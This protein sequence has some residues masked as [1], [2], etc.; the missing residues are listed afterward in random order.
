MKLR[1]VYIKSHAGGAGKWIYAGY[2]RAWESMGYE[3]VHYD[4]LSQID[5]EPNSYYLMAIDGTVS[6][7]EALQKV[8]DSYKTFLYVQPNEFPAPWGSH[9]NFQCHCPDEFIDKLNELKN[10]I[11][12]VFGN[13]TKYHT[14]W[15]KFINYIPL[16]FDNISYQPQKDDNYAY[17]ICFVGGW[18]DNG[19]NEKRAIMLAHFDELKKLNINMGICIN[20]G[21]SVQDEANLLYNSKISLNIHDQY[22]RVYGDDS[23]ERTFKS[24]GL[25][26]FLICDKVREVKRLFPD[27]PTGESPAD[28]VEL[29]RKYLSTPLEDIKERNKQKILDKHTYVHRVNSFLSI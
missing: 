27:V 20:Q 13:T 19:F 5:E 3:V 23:N 4:A 6:D 10:V 9:P 21:I 14:K 16:A 28:F 1:K 24:L 22:Q 25:N 7:Q 12:W 8:V 26:G 17:D 29:V 11:F 18:A 15:K 2:G